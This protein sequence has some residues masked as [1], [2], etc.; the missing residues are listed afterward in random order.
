MNLIPIQDM[1]FEIASIKEKIQQ[2]ESHGLSPFE[3]RLLEVEKEKLKSLEKAMAIRTT[4][5]SRYQ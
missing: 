3:L 5:L 1:E 2:L 4:P